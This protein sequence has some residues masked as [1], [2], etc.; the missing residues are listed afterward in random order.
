MDC[1]E[2]GIIDR[3][4][5]QVRSKGRGNPGN[6]SSL[7]GLF[8]ATID[9]ARRYEENRRYEDLDS[10]SSEI[11]EDPVWTPRSPDPAEPYTPSDEDNQPSFEE[12]NTE[13]LDQMTQIRDRARADAERRH[14]D[15]IIRRAAARERLSAL[16]GV[17]LGVP[18]TGARPTLALAGVYSEG[19]TVDQMDDLSRTPRKNLTRSR[20]HR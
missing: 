13:T 20:S 7:G 3:H 8:Q 14:R 19:L 5:H 12:T 10:D 11:A 4:I 1:A 16:V 2:N 6:G 9:R 17:G 18:V 15:L